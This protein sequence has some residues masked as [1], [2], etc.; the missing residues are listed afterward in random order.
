MQIYL[1]FAEKQYI[2]SKYSFKKNEN[3]TSTY[4]R[5]KEAAEAAGS[6]LSEV[7]RKA[8]VDRS[9]IERWKVKEP[10]TIGTL[11]ALH[12]A[13]KEVADKNGKIVE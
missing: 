6:T 12:K 3:M 11:N 10:K 8:N 7:C 5:L 13:I 9:V 2:C 4:E 1:I